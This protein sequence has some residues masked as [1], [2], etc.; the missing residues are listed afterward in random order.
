LK[1]AVEWDELE[2]NAEQAA[3]YLKS[4]AHSGRLRILCHLCQGEMSVGALEQALGIRQAAV[5]QLLAKLRET[6]LVKTRRE[7]KTIYYS[8]AD[9]DTTKIIEV[10]Y[11][12]FCNA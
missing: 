8:L 11:N 7:G 12:K 3:G 1:E 9:D 6:R 2:R 10:M 5:S 4:M